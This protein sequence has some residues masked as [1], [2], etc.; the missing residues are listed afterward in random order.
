MDYTVIDLETANTDRASICK[1]A[2][3]IVRGGEVIIQKDFYVNPQQPFDPSFTKLHGIT[4]EKVESAPP[5]NRLHALL[6]KY[7]V[8]ATMVSH[9]VFDRNALAV[10][11]QRAGLNWPDMHWIDTIHVARSLW[12]GSADHKL[13]TLAA[14]MGMPFRHHDPMDDAL[15][16]HE[17]LLRGLRSSKKSLA[18]W[19]ERWEPPV[20]GKPNIK[21]KIFAT[22]SVTGKGDSA[23]SYAGKCLAFTGDLQV[24]REKAAEAA[25]RAGFDVKSSVSFKTHIVVKGQPNPDGTLT[26]KEK[27]ARALIGEGCNIEIIDES[28]FIRRLDI[29]GVKID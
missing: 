22:Q 28:E 11:T 4:A 29:A 2:M 3:I 17:V 12:P 6:S 8:K 19:A 27:R 14:A 16:A 1:M 9:G 13:P 7:F 18:D 10:A 23:G 15:V 25:M 5:F 20:Y 26:S 21:G 24:E